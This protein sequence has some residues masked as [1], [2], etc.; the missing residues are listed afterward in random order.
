MDSAKQSSVTVKP[1]D[2][3]LKVFATCT[4]TTGQRGRESTSQKTCQE[5]QTTQPMG[6]AP[7]CPGWLRMWPSCTEESVCGFVWFSFSL[8]V[9]LPS[10]H[11][12][13]SAVLW[14]Q[15][16]GHRPYWTRIKTKNLHNQEKPTEQPPL[17]R[18]GDCGKLGRQQES[19][20][21]E[22]MLSIRCECSPESLCLY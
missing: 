19:T 18:W 8:R 10:A 12:A 16:V 6:G 17:H 11:L 9:K 2:R 1:G 22:V 14:G 5:N 20:E 13:D 7:C 4:W 21:L 3:A 15:K